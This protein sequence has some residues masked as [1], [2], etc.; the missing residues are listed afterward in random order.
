MGKIISLVNQKGGVGKTTTSINLAA[1]LGLLGKKVLLVDLD[2]QGNTTTG[3]GI[4]KGDLNVSIYD[5]LIGT[6]KPEESVK[7]TK[8][9]NLSIIPS[10]ITLAGIDIEFMEKTRE[11]STFF[12][13]SQ[14][15]RVLYGLRDNYDYVLIDCP[16]SLGILT[17]NALTASDSVLIPVQCEYFALEGIMQLLNTITQ[18]RKNLNPTLEIEGVVLTMLDSRTNLGLEVVEN[19]RG[20]FRERVYDTIIPRLIRL[21]EAPSHGKPIANYDPTSRG[22]EAYINLAKEVIA[23]NE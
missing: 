18:A 8:F 23:R 12:K 22:T 13:G 17:I 19:V 5:A 9:K 20:F 3:V 14:L 2:P 6:I 4:E 7:K 16:P 10:T 11:D 1:S 21:T 15:K